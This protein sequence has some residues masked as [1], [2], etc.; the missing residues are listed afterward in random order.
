MLRQHG[1]RGGHGGG[2]GEFTAPR[3]GDAGGISPDFP[4]T[5]NPEPKPLTQDPTDPAHQAEP[6]CTHVRPEPY[7]PAKTLNDKPRI[8]YPAL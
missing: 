1:E 6:Y 4:Q 3:D 2:D 5:P 7:S 8:M